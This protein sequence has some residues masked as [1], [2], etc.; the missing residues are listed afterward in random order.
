MTDADLVQG[1]LDSPEDDAPRL[2]Y[3]DWLEDRGDPDSL[4]RAEFIR[5]QI[6]LAHDPTSAATSW[7]AGR[8]TC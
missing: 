1:V 7:S 3:A 6:E 2:V 4:A 8:T 5:V